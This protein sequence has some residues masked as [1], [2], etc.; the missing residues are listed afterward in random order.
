[1]QRFLFLGLLGLSLTLAAEAASAH[2]FLKTANPPVGGTVTTAPAEL[3]INFTEAVEPVFSKIT[4]QDANGAR[5]DAGSVH[6]VAGDAA[7]LAVALKKLQP[8][9]YTVIWHAT[10]VDTHK[11][12][13]KF[14]FTV[15]P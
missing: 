3:R 7:A 9:S 1:M 12:Q 14:T 8:G 4:V 2:A 6:D 13:G 5:M 11:T 15:A 10:S